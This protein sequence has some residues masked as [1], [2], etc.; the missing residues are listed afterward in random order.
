MDA[1]EL[2]NRIE[3]LPLNARGHRLNTAAV[4]RDVVAYVE[5]RMANG[6]SQNLGF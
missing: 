4:K 2:K 5:A 1:N 6:A 3:E